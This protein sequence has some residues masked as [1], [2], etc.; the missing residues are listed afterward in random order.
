LTGGGKNVHQIYLSGLANHRLKDENVVDHIVDLV[1]REAV[2]I[3]T[4]KF[5]L[6]SGSDNSSDRNNSLGKTANLK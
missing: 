4:S 3:E 1:E 6:K 5:K 2:K